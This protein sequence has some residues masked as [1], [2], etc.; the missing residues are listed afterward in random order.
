MTGPAPYPRDM[1]GYGATRPDPA[2]PGGARVAVQFVINYEEG[3]ENNIL[4]GDAASEAFLSEIV[5]AQPIVGARHMNME[6]LYE[7]GSRIGVWRLL[8]LFSERGLPFTVF[9][10]GMALE[11]YPALA[12]AFVAAGG[13]IASHGYRWIDYQKLPEEIEAADLARAVEV[14]RAITGSRPLGWYLGRCSPN[15]HRL[16]AAE[17]G[18]LY[19]ADSYADD[20]PYWDTAHPRPDGA[21][22]LIVPYT[23]DVNDMRFSTPAGFAQGEDFFTY[24]RDTFDQLHDEGAHSPAMMSVGLHCRLAGR[25]GRAR[26]LAR[27]MDHVMQRGGAWVCTREAIARH[28][29]ATHPAG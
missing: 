14:Q 19:N 28:W 23:L 3:G 4:H 16:V 11:R 13:E 7:Y 6:S 20:L 26:A 22:Q 24:L 25:P 21:A 17:G 9:A 2:W 1:I 29:M 12:E 5:S 15:T 10:V 18:F 27:F 8:R